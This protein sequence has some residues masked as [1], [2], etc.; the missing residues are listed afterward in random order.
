MPNWS[1]F[2]EEINK[3]REG[4]DTV[5]RKYLK[6]LH[7]VSNKNV[8]AYYSGWLNKPSAKNALI[9]DDDK[10]G[11]MAAIN[12]LNRSLGLILILHT[13]GGEIGATESLI[14]YL[15][16]MFS[17]NIIAIIPQIA[18]SAGTMVACASKEIIMGKESNLGPIDPQFNGIPM[19]G[20]LDEFDRAILEVKKD[21][22]SIPIWQQIVSKYHPTF[23]G[24]CQKGIKWAEDVV[25][26]NLIE[27]MFSG[28]NEASEKAEKVYRGLCAQGTEKSHNRHIPIE[29]CINIGLNVKYLEN[30]D[31]IK[32]LQDVVLTIHHSYMH[33]FSQTLAIKIVENHQGN[34]I[35]TFERN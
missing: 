11:F 33:T 14:D 1:K 4:I 13:P 18:M 9:N 17:N 7:D 20:V 21:R 30:Y 10:N 32:D 19:Q 16:K 5:R 35:V 24:E 26:K 28:D 22:D 15:R 25:I 23:I 3:Y 2:L 27:C 31:D 8:I 34:G 12:G 29:E 6:Q